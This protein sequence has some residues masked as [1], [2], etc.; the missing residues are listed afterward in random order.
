MR[1]S[2]SDPGSKI[3]K[4][5]RPACAVTTPRAKDTVWIPTVGKQGLLILTRDGKIQ[6]HRAEVAA[7]VDHGGRMVAL[8]SSDATTVWAQ[9]EVLMT[10]WRR[11]EELAN[12]PGPFIY[13]ATR[14]S[15]VKVV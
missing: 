14:T 11:T 9:L 10:Q 15:L 6:Q 13:A 2:Q 3:H 4:H 1:P 5:I 12:L 8:S 7:V